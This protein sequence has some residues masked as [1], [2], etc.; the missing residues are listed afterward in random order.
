MNTSREEVLEFMNSDNYHGMDLRTFY[1]LFNLTRV[2]LISLLE[3]Y[4]GEAPL[5]IIKITPNEIWVG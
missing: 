1:D 3:E 5:E 4:M 2:E